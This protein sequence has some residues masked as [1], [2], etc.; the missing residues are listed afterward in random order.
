MIKFWAVAIRL[1]V[2]ITITVIIT[3]TTYFK[4][5]TKGF[6]RGVGAAYQ[7]GAAQCMKPSKAFEDVVWLTPGS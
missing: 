3:A 4:A 2:L 7:R 5:Y 6:D 1:W